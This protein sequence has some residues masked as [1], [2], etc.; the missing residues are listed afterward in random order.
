MSA[1]ASAATDAERRRIFAGALE[2]VRAAG[3]IAY[4]TETLWAL[5]ADA[6]STAAL[7]RLGRWKRRSDA[8]PI[9]VLVEGLA[10]LA[11]LGIE[12]DDRARSLAGA[13]W[14]G[15]LT[16]VL[17]CRR[18]FAPGVARSDGA[19]GVRCSPHP[20]AAELAA[21][22]AAAGLGPLTATSLNRHGEPPA[23]T[24]ADAERMCVDADPGDEGDAPLLVGPDGCEAG[25][26][27]P[28]SVVDLTGARPRLL[29]R[30]ALDAAVLSGA[31]GGEE[32]LG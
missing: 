9:A 6:S 30:G 32:C 17:P 14:P 15:P 11:P 27:T 26:G 3:L 18:A 31:L 19:V 23:R 7:E 20:V 10:S 22:V 24:R 4:P 5:G 1:L 12:V 25:G 16:L 2:R 29:R 21:A 28:S 13:F 8:Q